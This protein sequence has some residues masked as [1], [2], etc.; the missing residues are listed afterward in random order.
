[1][2][3]GEL[4]MTPKYFTCGGLLLKRFLEFLEQANVFNRDHGLSR[5]RFETELD[6]RS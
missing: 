2:S 3:V 1:M 5:K 6:L 4:A